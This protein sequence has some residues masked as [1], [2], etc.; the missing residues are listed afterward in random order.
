MLSSPGP[1]IAWKTVFIIEYL[2]P[3][4]IHPAILLLRPYI[5]HNHGEPVPHPA[6]AQT[7]SMWLIVMHFCKREFE[8]LFIHRFSSATMPAM[9]IF[10]NS[11]HYWILA[12]LNIALFTYSPSSSCP[13]TRSQPYPWWNAVAIGLFLVGE[14]GNLWA[15]IILMNLRS[16]GGAERGIPKGG[17]FSFI[18]VTCPNYFFEIVA[19][20][21]IWMANR[22]WSTA[23]FI[24][25]AAFQMA[26][27]AQKKERRYR[28]E[29][30]DGYKKRRS[31]M[32]PFI[33]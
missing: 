31:V 22:S 32:I 24:A 15:H 30:G 21:G 9:N 14:L 29:F 1:Q 20:L 8:T 4:L 28:R 3:L 6:I 19:W 2:G 26:V 10:K 5:F 7:L 16:A 33:F 13:T 12:G 18:P 25:V 17:V 11:A 27:W 23:I